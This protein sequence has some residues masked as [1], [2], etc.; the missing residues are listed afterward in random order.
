MF[1]TIEDVFKHDPYVFMDDSM[2]MDDRVRVSVI[3]QVTTST[4]QDLAKR[5]VHLEEILGA[6]NKRQRNQ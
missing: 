1:K 2:D 3:Q 6:G 4:V 5:I